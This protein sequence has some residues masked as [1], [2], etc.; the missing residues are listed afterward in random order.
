[1]EAKERPLSI[2]NLIHLAKYFKAGRMYIMMNIFVLISLPYHHYDMQN[3]YA[4]TVPV[5]YLMVACT[6]LLGQ[7]HGRSK[8][9]PAQHLG[10]LTCVRM[11]LVVFFDFSN[12]FFQA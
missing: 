3:Y 5:V 11:H 4:Y 8:L 1:M 12:I 6:D 7:S 10:C 2:A 9:Q